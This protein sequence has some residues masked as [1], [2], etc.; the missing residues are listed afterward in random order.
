MTGTP[1]GVENFAV[2]PTNDRALQ[3]RWAPLAEEL[4]PMEI[5]IEVSYGDKTIKV[6][7]F[8]N[9]RVATLPDLPG[10]AMGTARLLIERGQ[11]TWSSASLAF[12]IPSE[13][14]S[15][16]AK[17]GMSPQESFAEYAFGTQTSTPLEMARRNSKVVAKTSFRALRPEL[18]YFVQRSTDLVTWETISTVT[19]P[20]GDQFDFEDEQGVEKQYFYRSGAVPK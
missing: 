9:D 18:N 7:A 15:F 13:I 3:F 10:G 2:T 20:S 16:A 4:L 17:R 11:N 5:S 6:G 19:P 8:L 1:T 12:V 14:Q